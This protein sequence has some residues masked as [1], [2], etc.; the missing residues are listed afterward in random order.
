[1]AQWELA[2]TL[3]RE[4]G[5]PVFRQIARAI[6]GDIARGR[7]RPGT[8]LPGT[9]TLAHRLEVN[10]NTVLAAYDELIAEEWL[11]TS[12]AS[13][14]FVS[15]RL[16][17][18]PPGPSEATVQ[19]R[20]A[21]TVTA[22]RFRPA[23][24]L[25]RPVQWPQGTLDI[26]G[27]CPDLASIRS[28]EL[29][30][31]YRRALRL[32]H[33]QLLG[34]CDP[35]GHP[36]LRDAFAKM[37]SATRSLPADSANILITGGSQMSWTLLGLSLLSP[38]DTIAVE[39]LGYRP[40]WE[41]FRQ[42]GARLSPVPVDDAGLQ[43]D[44]LSG[45]IRTERLRAVYITP[46]RQYP[47]TVTMSADRRMRLLD[48]AAR[49][50]FAIIEDDYDHEFHDTGRPTQPL[51]SLDT[52]G[53]VIYVGTLSKVFAPGLRIGFV[54]APA[55]LVESLTA[56]R[57]VLDLHGDH[58]VEAAVAELLNDGEIQRH[59]NRLRRHY[60]ARRSTLLAALEERLPDVVRAT[61]SEGGLG[62]WCS[63]DSDINVDAWAQ[64]ARRHGAVFHTG[65]RYAFSGESLPN[66][67]LSF[68]P[69]NESEIFEAIRR[70]A[71]ALPNDAP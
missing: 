52:R 32:G 49:H 21:S 18:P 40:A 6:A 23:P 30:R 2:I 54:V 22:F 53:I 34:Y 44:A 70:I 14:T 48:L 24:V 37:V 7:L 1:M 66:I 45:I 46:H 62:V 55:S 68:A 57:M 51:A 42:I 27:G 60:A 41:A 3:D 20:N 39:A 15:S 17:D 69:L 50:G 11:T 25:P 28:E 63:V 47:T 16:P 31:A 67:R 56:R 59:A 4:T 71:A 5:L 33:R 38:G 58:V 13:G 9:R 8:R 19:G 35:A 43:V 65:R 36:R 64:R 61:P 29:S 10:R 26:S 12:A